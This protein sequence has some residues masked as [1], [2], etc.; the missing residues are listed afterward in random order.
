MVLLGS[1]S[2]ILTDGEPVGSHE[3]FDKLI[4]VKSILDED[5]T[6]ESELKYLRLIESIRDNQPNLFEKIKRLPKKARS[7]KTQPEVMQQIFNKARN[8]DS[9]LTFFRKGKLMKFYLATENSVYEID[10]LTAA[11]IFETSS[12]LKPIPFD[13]EKYYSLLTYNKI[14]FSKI[15]EEEEVSHPRGKDAG[16]EL[17]KYLK[18]FKSLSNQLTD[19]QE[20]YINE[21]IDAV[22]KGALPKQ[23]IRN[24]ITEIK[25]SLKNEK[26]PLKI[27]NVI[28]KAIPKEFFTKH[29]AELKMSLDDKKEIILSLFLKGDEK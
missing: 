18:A 16:K 23:L 1:D 26:D 22:Q 8:E 3:L 4:S 28:K 27:F 7:S 2:A 25:N 13:T 10:F 15:L 21:I 11:K 12:E 5:E 19:K 24:I 20:E 29:L 14:E 9:L 17:I 6:E